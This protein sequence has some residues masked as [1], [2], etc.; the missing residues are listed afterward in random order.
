VQ[1]TQADSEIEEEHLLNFVV[2]S[3]ERFSMTRSF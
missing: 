1:P 3:L 2:N